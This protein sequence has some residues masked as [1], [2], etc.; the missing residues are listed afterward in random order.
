[1]IDV[2]NASVRVMESDIHLDDL[3]RLVHGIEH[4]H[5]IDLVKHSRYLQQKV[6]PGYRPDH[7]PREKVPG[8]LARYLQ[9]HSESTGSVLSKWLL[10]NHHICELVKEEVHVETIED[11]I[12]KILIRLDHIQKIRDKLLWALFL[13]E[14]KE[15][16]TA[17]INGLHETLINETSPLMDRVERHRLKAALERTNQDMG[18]LKAERDLL[19]VQN[20]GMA[21]LQADMQRLN[22]TIDQ[23]EMQHRSEISR[24]DKTL[25]EIKNER[26]IAQQELDIAQQ[27]IGKLRIELES[28]Q[29]RN[30]EIQ[31]SMGNLRDSLD[32]AVAVSKSDNSG[33]AKQ[34]LHEALQVLEEE[35][36]VS[37]SLRQRE[38][39]LHLSIE[40]AERERNVAYE[41]R[42]EERARRDKLEALLER[43]ERAKEALISQVRKVSLE[44]KLVTN[45]RD[46]AYK[47]LSQVEENA[48][49][50][51]VENRKLEAGLQQTRAELNEMFQ[52]LDE[53][54]QKSKLS[55]EFSQIDDR[56]NKAVNAIVQHIALTLPSQESTNQA[57]QA[58]EKI[59]DWRS[60]QRLE[61]SFIG[62]L[63]SSLP[64][65]RDIV[66]APDLHHLESAQKLLQ[67][68]WYLLELLKLNILE[69]ML[70]ESRALVE[71]KESN[72]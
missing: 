6:F 48:N 9:E 14:R 7:L 30:T 20:E 31:R 10:T 66:G 70:V 25:Q 2:K 5:I 55:L 32:T 24:R 22:E 27:E 15:I 44:L 40:K 28:E 60:W 49:A 17:L 58:N 1:M 57:L 34:Q 12:V 67:L 42:D 8:K 56:W 64:I 39:N 65:K 3:E 50:L 18:Q 19:R 21:L 4:S 69:N 16:Q 26:D 29:S 23:L 59:K 62:P 47:N 11:D 43:T 51:V 33:T 54:E 68:R 13:D 72:K 45:E 46:S 35:R 37:A 36:K 63:L 38:T 52:L 61:E 41:K 71:M 53:M